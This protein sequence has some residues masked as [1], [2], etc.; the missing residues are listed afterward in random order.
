MFLLSERALRLHNPFEWK[1][2][3]EKRPDLAILDIGN[4]VWKNRFIPCGAPYH[5]QVLQIKV[6]HIECH[7][8]STYGTRGRIPP[9][10][11]E[12]LQHPAKGRPCHVVNDDVHSVLT[13]TGNDI[14]VTCDDAIS[15]N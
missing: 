5:H 13:Q 2:L 12:H 9:P 1:R 6:T 11:L 15:S 7:K 10:S 4:K 8:W 3:C 14:V